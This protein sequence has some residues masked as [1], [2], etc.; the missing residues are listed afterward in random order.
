MPKA[1]P[2][3]VPNTATPLP[4]ALVRKIATYR[5]RPVREKAALWMY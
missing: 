4:K 2:T 1:K 5:V 3:T